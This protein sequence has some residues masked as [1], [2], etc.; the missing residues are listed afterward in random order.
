MEVG[1]LNEEPDELVLQVSQLDGRQTSDSRIGICLPYWCVRVLG[2]VR[3]SEATLNMFRMIVAREAVTEEAD[4]RSGV[5][6]TRDRD[7]L[8]IQGQISVGPLK[9]LAR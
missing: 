4:H 2:M 7:G 9:T 3:S 6:V 8:D 1:S 5:M